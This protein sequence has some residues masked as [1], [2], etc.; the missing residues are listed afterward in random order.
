MDIRIGVQDTAR[1]VALES[2]L[3]PAEASTL[4]DAA[5]SNGS[6]LTLT[7][8]KGR[9]IMVPGAKIAFAEIGAQNAGRVGF[10]GN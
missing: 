9:T 6:T 3:T 10:G 1:E 8:T 2:D 5:I 4:I 7:D